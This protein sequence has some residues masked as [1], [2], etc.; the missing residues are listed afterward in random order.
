MTSR[1]ESGSILVLR[2]GAMGDVLHAMPA[3]AALRHTRPDARIG[4]IIERRWAP[5]L[6]GATT[7][8][9]PL[10]DSIHEVD[11]RGWRKQMWSSATW[12]DIRAVIAEVRS[13][14]YADGIDV[15]GAIKSALLGKLARTQRLFGFAHPRESFS[16]LAYTRKIVTPAAHVIDQNLE[17]ASA[18][19]GTRLS[20][21]DFDLAVDMEA[22]AWADAEL[23]RLGLVRFAIVSPG[24]GWGAKNWPPSRY[25]EVA[26]KLASNGVRSIV[27]F[28]PGEESLAD[29][30]VAE[31]DHTAVAL[32]CSLPQLLELTRRCAVFIG[33]DTGPMHLAAALKRPVVALFGPTDPA[34]N[35]PY[36]T[37]A[38]V[39]RNEKSRTSYRHVASADDGLMSITTDE[40]VS[41]AEKLLS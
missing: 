2:L 12:S 11:T 33:G 26:R 14:H 3:V 29:E 37:A 8:G 38:V 6:R 4:W 31:S 41:A 16:T 34:R 7:G 27:N 9:R 21:G 39:L 18:L 10:V 13:E 28:G 32:Q 25:A 20:A 36:G 23:Q 17:L 1:S 5:F 22:A 40:V 24:S 19:A 30:L 15:Q 35:G